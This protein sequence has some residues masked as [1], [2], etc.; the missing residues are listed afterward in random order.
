M[1]SIS[2]PDLEVGAL[3]LTNYS[4]IPDL[5]VGAIDIQKLKDLKAEPLNF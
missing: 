1:I 4:N 2:F 5:K 3:N